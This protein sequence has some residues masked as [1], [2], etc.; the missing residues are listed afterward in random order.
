MATP[1]AQHKPLPPMPRARLYIPTR[2]RRGRDLQLGPEQAH[3]LGRVLRMKTGSE[4][5]VFDGSGDE[6]PAIVSSFRKGSATLQ[7]GEPV[8]RN[9]ESPLR[10][11]LVQ[12]VSRG[13]R[14]DFVVQKATELGVSE[15]QPVLTDRTVVRLDAER[16]ERRQAH[17]Q[18]VAISACE[19][20]GRNR[21]PKIAAPLPLGDFLAADRD[22][23]I[24]IRLSPAGPNRLDSFDAPGEGWVELLV[25]PEGGLSETEGNTASSC[26]F[27]AISMGPRI[28]RTETAALTAIA[29][30]QARWGDLA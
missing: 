22:A 1:A 30:I 14:M 9:L 7:P 5:T 26:G 15:I 27:S 13:E 18:R 10:I 8:R 24:R 11:R 21:L 6:F 25:G 28:L 4:L 3:Y 12:G 19:Q 17:W 20:C 16:T 2:I 23:A 29:L